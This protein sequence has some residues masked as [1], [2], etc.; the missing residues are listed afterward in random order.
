MEKAINEDNHYLSDE[1]DERFRNLAEEAF[2]DME[3]KQIIVTLGT[4][5]H[6]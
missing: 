4:I 2:Q 5:H 1:H 6:C 3:K